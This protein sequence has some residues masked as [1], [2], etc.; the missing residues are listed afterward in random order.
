MKMKQRA[1]P[2]NF[3]CGAGHWYLLSAPQGGIC[4]LQNRVLDTERITIHC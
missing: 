3:L 1:N 2:E 4:A